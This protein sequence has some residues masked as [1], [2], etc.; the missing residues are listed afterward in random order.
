MPVKYE[1]Q[2]LHW[3]HEQ[4]TV[5]SGLM[6]YKGEKS[7]HPY[8]SHEIKHDQY[9]VESV[10][11]EML[12]GVEVK[13]NTTIVIESDN[14]SSQYK[15]TAHFDSN[16]R[17][18]DEYR[19]KIVRFFGIPEHGKGEVDHVGGVAKTTIRREIAAC[20]FFSSVSE[21]VAM[22]KKWFGDQEQP[23]YVIK[24]ITSSD[25]LEKHVESHLKVFKTVDGSS[26]FQVFFFLFRISP[27]D[28]KNLF[29]GACGYML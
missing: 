16:Q 26:K 27:Q 10:L 1:P 4:I 15:S 12:G 11:T 7:Y 29:Q 22:L 13:R 25:V 2:S 3:C 8:L 5:H 23:K 21:M 6:K 18:A 19:V 17:L 9:F 20:E 14:C 24:E 28:P